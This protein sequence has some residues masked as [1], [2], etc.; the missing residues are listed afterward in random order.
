MAAG[1]PCR[2]RLAA[3][4]RLIQCHFMGL[5]VLAAIVPALDIQQVVKLVLEQSTA[6]NVA[7]N[8]HRPG[9]VVFLEKADHHLQFL[10]GLCVFIGFNFRHLV[11]SAPDH[12]ARMIAVAQDKI[13]IWRSPNSGQVH[14]AVEIG[15]IGPFIKGFI[16]DHKA[17][18]VAQVQQFG[19]GHIMAGTNRIAAHVLHD[20]QLAFH[21]PGQ[22]HRPQ[23]AVVM[24][25]VNAIHLYG[26]V[27]KEKSFVGVKS[28]CA[29]TKRC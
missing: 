1:A 6:D 21:R 19:G 3:K 28:E 5:D 12:N 22:K 17:H 13:L 23:R 20:F 15:R 27:V 9:W 25:Q 4:G 7:G 16:E 24:M 11:A 2:S 18:P 10:A 8:R 14:A 26:T 29:D